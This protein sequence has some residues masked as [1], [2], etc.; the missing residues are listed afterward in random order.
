MSYN[1]EHIDEYYKKHLKNLESDTSRDRWGKLSLMLF[2][3]KYGLW[4]VLLL[5]AASA[6][7]IGI[8]SVTNEQNNDDYTRHGENQISNL[9]LISDDSAIGSLSLQETIKDKPALVI[10]ENEK[11]QS[12]LYEV[13]TTETENH[14]SAKSDGNFDSSSILSEN[15]KLKADI[16][17]N[18]DDFITGYLSK[19]TFKNISEF[20]ISEK[21]D[22]IPEI[23]GRP[24]SN[25]LATLTGNSFKPSRAT[26]WS[27]DIYIAPSY[28][29]KSLS[30]D[31]IYEDYINFRKNSEGPIYTTGLGAEIKFSI[32]KW[33]IQS[34]INY[35]VYGDNAKYNFITNAIDSL[36][37]YYNIDT[38][39]VWIYDPPFI[40]EPYPIGFDSVWMPVYK[41]IESATSIQN[42]YGYIEI[43]VLFG[44]HTTKKKLNFEIGTGI[45]FG[46]LVSAKGNLPDLTNNSL[47]EI[48]N[49]TEFIR[50]TSI[51]YILNAGIQYQIS[52]RISLIVKPYYKRNLSYLFKDDYPI[53]QKYS[54]FGV[55]TGINVKL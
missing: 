48:N 51:N 23:T 27:M 19:L 5:I 24:D 6:V 2:R 17:S 9:G 34:G 26:S 49:S 21:E 8:L 50:S 14:I 11:E 35:S 3:K 53:K 25:T 37:S 39:Y 54:T 45:S 18:S 41:E 30:A 43:P 32:N 33:F 29:S 38:T 1:L 28:V 22:V 16:T 55:I 42:R 52:K 12:V 47:V 15:E 46:F 4:I 13:S 31:P 36:K 20:K 44:F 40:G 7:I 10:V